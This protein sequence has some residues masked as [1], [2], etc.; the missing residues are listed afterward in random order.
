MQGLLGRVDVSTTQIFTHVMN[1]P[2]LGVRSPLDGLRP[3]ALSGGARNGVEVEAGR[4]EGRRRSG[5]GGGRIGG[6]NS[7]WLASFAQR[8]GVRRQNGVPTALSG[9]PK[10]PYAAVLT[11]A[12]AVSRS[13]SRLPPHSTTWRRW[14]D[15]GGYCA[16]GPGVP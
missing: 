8:L 3:K 13:Q 7:T 9:A 11:Y 6:D 15:A 16:K 14:G 5:D 1:R 12:K 10:H 4:T 2:G